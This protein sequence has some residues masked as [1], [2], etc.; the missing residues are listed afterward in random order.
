MGNLK[1]E[2]RTILAVSL[3]S[4]GVDICMQSKMRTTIDR[5]AS[6]FRI[7][8]ATLVALGCSWVSVE[9]LFDRQPL[10][11]SALGG[12][13]GQLSSRA[14]ELESTSD[15][16]AALAVELHVTENSRKVLESR[17]KEQEQ[18]KRQL[19]SLLM[20]HE[21]A[22]RQLKQRLEDAEF[23]IVEAE[24]KAVK[25]QAKVYNRRLGGAPS[26]QGERGPAALQ[27]LRQGRDKIQDNGSKLIKDDLRIPRIFHRI[28]IPDWSAWE[29]QASTACMPRRMHI[30]TAAA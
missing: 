20:D 29:A 9:L 21:D 11:R 10:T 23:K 16:K 13:E 7:V 19:E 30:C 3:R 1:S 12:Y 25:A 6:L 26:G 14:S 18:Q 15:T 5:R 22:G 27:G 4:V 17:L 24:R 2:M 28:H 8:L